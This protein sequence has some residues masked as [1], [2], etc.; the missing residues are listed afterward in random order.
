MRA[1]IDSNIFIYA[2]SAD[3]KFGEASEKIIQDIQS[4]K[5]DATTTTLNIAEVVEIIERNAD[6]QKAILSAEAL[7][8]IPMNIESVEKE[9]AIEATFIF[10]SSKANFSD[11]LFVSVMR[12]KFIETIITNDSDF[13]SIKGI[14]VIKP[15]EYEKKVSK[16]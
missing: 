13:D 3:S 4:G 6:K 5:I 12:E 14:K 8:Q 9:H 2:L 16:V 11:T 15:L 1:F 7:L 10:S